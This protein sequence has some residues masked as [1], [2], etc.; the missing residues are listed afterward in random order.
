MYRTLPI[1]T[2]VTG[3]ISQLDL[4]R[5]SGT[6]QVDGAVTGSVDATLTD[7]T[8]PAQ[9]GTM[10]M[11]SSAPSDS[12]KPS[13]LATASDG[14][15]PQ[16]LAAPADMGASSPQVTLTGTNNTAQFGNL[17]SVGS[18]YDDSCPAGQALIGFDGNLNYV[19]NRVRAY[20]GILRLASVGK[21]YVVRVDA[22]AVLPVRGTG[23][24]GTSWSRLCAQ[25]QVLVGFAGRSGLAIDQ[26]TFRCAPLQVSSGQVLIGPINELL[27]VGGTGG[28]AFG[29]E[30]CPAGQVATVARIRA[31]DAIYAFGL[32]C[33]A[34]G[35]K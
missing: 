35:L 14:T 20:C 17:T 16:D 12:A 27:P 13:D 22:G 5:L 7:A 24:L 6:A 2:A 19:L 30:D 18:P 11:D 23:T 25:D 32:A 1:F 28:T 34:V 3:C 8:I 33:S 4:E 21:G 26:L 9:D 15:M 29:P 31:S 10:S